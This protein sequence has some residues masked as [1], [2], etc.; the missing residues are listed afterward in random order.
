MQTEQITTAS[1]A[2]WRK[3]IGFFDVVIA[4][5]LYLV[6]QILAGILVF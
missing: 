1:R 6:L 4:F 3:R 5:V 2:A